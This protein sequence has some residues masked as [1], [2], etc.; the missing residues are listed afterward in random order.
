M[1]GFAVI[2]GAAIAVGADFLNLWRNLILGFITG[3]TLT[4]S[5]MAVNDYYDR[6]VDAINEPQRPIPSGAVTPAGALL[7]W[8]IL[9]TLGLLV[10]WLTNYI[11]LVVTVFA[12]IIILFY[13][14]RGKRTGL[15]GNLLVSA[16]IALPFIYG[17]IAVMDS[18]SVSSLLFA[19]MALLSNTGREVTKG[20]VDVEGDKA[21]GIRT[22]AVSRGVRTAAFTAIVLYLSAICIS[23]LPLA[24]GLVSFWYIPFVALTDIGF[25]HASIM[26]IINQDRENS[27]KVKNNILIW[28]IFGLVGSLTGSFL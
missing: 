28:M 10:A 6:E 9:S 17:G 22:V 3:F 25:I 21:N 27:R 15:F 13:S 11:C 4:G 12:W 18:L 24:L 2:V 5:A 8:L 16:C 1:V 23:F 26:L 20:I 7:Y 14:I 19:L